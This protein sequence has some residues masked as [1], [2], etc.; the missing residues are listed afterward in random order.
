L[1]P[2]CVGLKGGLISEPP[3]YYIMDSTN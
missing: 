3:L 2:F 1:R